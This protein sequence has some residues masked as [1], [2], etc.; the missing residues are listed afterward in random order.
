MNDC[1]DNHELAPD[2]VG[3]DVGGARNDEFAGPLNPAGTTRSRKIREAL[4]HGA[5]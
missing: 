5:D 1:H 3:Y 2:P 4:N